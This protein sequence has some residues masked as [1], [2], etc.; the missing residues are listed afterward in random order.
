MVKET[1]SDKIILHP[2]KKEM[3]KLFSAIVDSLLPDTMLQRKALPNEF[4]GE[5][6]TAAEIDPDDFELFSK[7]YPNPARDVLAIELHEKNKIEYELSDLQGRIVM[8]GE[9]NEL[10]N[11]ID[12][13]GQAQGIYHLTLTN[14][15][16]KK[17]EAV[18]IIKTE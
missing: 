1:A 6:N 7:V 15:P 8:K 16:D 11:K 9:F 14:P 2:E 10:I 4:A 13:S 3:K 12:I 5:I 17:R 18:K